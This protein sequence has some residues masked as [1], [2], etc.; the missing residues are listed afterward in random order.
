MTDPKN[1]GGI[2]PK[3]VIFCGGMGTRIRGVADDVP[4][5]MV[6]IGKQP[7][8]WHIMKTYEKH[9]ME[10]FVLCLGHLGWRIKE[11]FLD[12]RHREVDLTV[13]LGTTVDVQAHDEPT[14]AWDVTLAE[15]GLATQTAGRLWQVR[16]HVGSSDI[17][18][19]TY[20]DGVADVDVT[21][22]VA[23]HRAHG[24]VATVTAVRPP[25][26][27]G[28]LMVDPASDLV[29]A[30]AEK[31]QSTSGWING[32]FFV[33]DQRIWNFLSGDSSEVLEREPLAAL[34]AAGELVMYRH[35]GF[36][37]PMDTYREWTLLNDLWA[38]DAAPWRTC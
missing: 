27:F 19:V 7:V 28:D 31:P 29:L 36:W 10:S 16:R 4:K 32:G 34:A 3:V 5:P 14:E 18:C 6:P 22:L 24:K 21:A 13:R 20:G 2:A 1:A 9:G 15:T 33:F 30:F 26:R 38:R 8:L 11:Y 37:Q 25:G 23:F 35:E 17:F 12:Y